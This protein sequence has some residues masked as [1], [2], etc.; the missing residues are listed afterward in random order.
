MEK[1][2][3]NFEL[4]IDCRIRWNQLWSFG[5]S[6]QEIQRNFLLYK[7]K[8]NKR[9]IYTLWVIHDSARINQYSHRDKQWNPEIYY[10]EWFVTCYE[11]CELELEKLLKELKKYK[12]NPYLKFIA[13]INCFALPVIFLSHE[14]NLF[15]CN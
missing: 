2:R 4:E 15:S 14:N 3:G 1:I 12:I 8:R 7:L 10:N 11:N 6:I 5:T 9:E 13:I